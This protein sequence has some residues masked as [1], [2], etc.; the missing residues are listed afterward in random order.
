[1]NWAK[2]SNQ[3]TGPQMDVRR[4]ELLK[5]SHGRQGI[6]V[7]NPGVTLLLHP[8]QDGEFFTPHDFIRWSDLV[9]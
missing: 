1:M 4:L 7:G 6:L 9:T 8:L 3:A 2:N 5:G